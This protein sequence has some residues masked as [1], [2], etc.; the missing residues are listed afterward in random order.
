M[1][2]RQPKY[3]MGQKFVFEEKVVVNHR[4]HVIVSSAVVTGIAASSTD[5]DF[6][7]HYELSV[8]FPQAY[9]SPPKVRPAVRETLLGSTYKLAG[10][11]Q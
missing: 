3:Q 7:Y 1:N 4:E 6:M 9:Y 8:E 2:V 5:S 10:E 11:S